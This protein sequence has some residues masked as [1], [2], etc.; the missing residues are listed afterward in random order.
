MSPT[1][2]QHRRKQHLSLQPEA[3]QAAPK[4][5]TSDSAL[6][7]QHVP[8]GQLK[9]WP[10]NPR[11]MPEAEMHK[12]VRSIQTFGL[13]EPLVVRR[14]DNLVIGGHQ[15]L[16]A[17]KA[18]NLPRVPV[19]FVAVSEAEAKALSLALN[20][21]EGEWDLPK[22]GALLDELR[23]LPDLDESLSGFD[24]KEA[25]ELL[26]QLERERLPEPYEESFD[27]ASEAL[28]E[29]RLAAPARVSRGEV[30]QLG[31]HRLLCGDSL[32][33][34]Q[35]DRLLACNKVDLVLTDPPY[36]VSYRSTLA[37]RGRRKQPI[38]NDGV[39][40]FEGLLSRA[41]PALRDV[42]KRGAALHWFAGGGGPEPVLAKALLAIAEHFTLLNI[43]VWDKLDPGLGWRWRRSW[44]A[45]IEAAVG[46][47]RIWNGGTEARNVLR[48][49]KAIPQADDH[50]TPKP[51]P[52]LEELIRAAAPSRGLI[53][54]PFCGS[55]S[56]LI[57]A[58]RTGRTCYA[59]ELE[60][61]YGDI[62]LARWEA[63]TRDRAARAE[64]E[65]MS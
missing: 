13:V 59:V 37:R 44:E 38:A 47:P 3:V 9:P 55:G 32:A 56:T 30:W 15:R 27:L 7:V 33:P 19:V 60:P 43:L 20:R 65:A 36:G 31:R 2:A 8:I 63:L 22:L 42:M 11:R 52:L 28:Q 39:D 54:D 41:L 64:K 21:I 18:L 23:E 24:E 53:L 5:P 57:A 17:A 29:Q 16:E 58:E 46:K 4:A 45:I 51:V 61:R 40:E 50:P 34:G 26:A 6:R 1:T 48:Y 62:V 35:L 49:A 12:L 25:E 10:G 14:Q